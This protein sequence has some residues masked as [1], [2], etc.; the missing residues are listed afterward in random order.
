MGFFSFLIVLSFMVFIHELGH[1]IAARYFGVTVHVFSI[2][3]GKK[4]YSKMYKGTEWRFAMIPLGGFV[5]MKGQ[6]DTKPSLVENGLDSYNQKKP[7]QRIVILFAGPFANFLLATILFFVIAIIG[8]HEISPTIGHIAKDSPADKGGLKIGDEIVTINDTQIQSWNDLSISIKDSSSGILTIIIKRNNSF[9]PITINPQ[10]GESVN[11]FGEKI[12]K[13]MVGIAP[14]Q[15]FITI[16]R[17]IFESTIYAI[18]R[19]YEASKMIFLGLQKLIAGIIPSTEVGGVISIG[20]VISE[21][22]EVG[23]IALFAITALIS[24]NLGVLNLLPIPALD[25]GHIMFNLY[26]IIARRK[27]NDKILL[28]LTIGGWVILISLMVLGLYND[29]NRLI[30]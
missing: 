2:G 19:T 16:E 10:I 28:N 7:W 26:E 21:A 17:N 13:R 3:F 30:G 12:Q 29:I 1:F 25:G 9:I 22:S 20:K 18:N 11:M 14:A 5:Q 27:P 4:I 15:K 6:D 23:I 8:S 24:V